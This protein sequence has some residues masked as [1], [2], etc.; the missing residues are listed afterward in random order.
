V[1]VLLNRKAIMD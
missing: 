1:Q